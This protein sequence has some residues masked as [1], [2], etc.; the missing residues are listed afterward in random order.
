MA[1]CR[2]EVLSKLSNCLIKQL[3]IQLKAKHQEIKFPLS[4]INPIDEVS[5]E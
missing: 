4:F 2:N 1:Q 3:L 5:V